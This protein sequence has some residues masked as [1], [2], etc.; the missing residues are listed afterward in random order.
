MKKYLNR[1]KSMISPITYG[2]IGYGN[3]KVRDI[4]DYESLEPQKFNKTMK[5]AASIFEDNSLAMDYIRREA[6]A[7]WAV[8]DYLSNREI[9]TEILLDAF[10]KGNLKQN[11]Y[12]KTSFEAGDMHWQT[13]VNRLDD[14]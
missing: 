4:R 3:Q 12:W 5:Y 7:Y 1:I 6:V 14:R 9:D 11:Q 8:M 13:I 10:K 2:V